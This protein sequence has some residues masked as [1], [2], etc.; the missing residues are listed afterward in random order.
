MTYAQYWYGDPWLAKTYREA[1]VERRK[2]ENVRDWL[3]G[4]YYYNALVTALSNAFRK[5]GAKVHPYLEEPF[6]IFPLTKEEREAKAAKDEAI[7]H[8]A[9]MRQA[10]Q[11]RAE[12]AAREQH[13]AE[14][15]DTG[16]GDS[17]DYNELEEQCPREVSD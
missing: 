13:N 16:T 11:M 3:Q 2:E 12:K 15:T 4:A 9:L 17:T 8:A 5:K 14:T 10:A 7:I 6:Q 1:Y